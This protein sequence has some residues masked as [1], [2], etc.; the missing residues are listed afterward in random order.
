[1]KIEESCKNPRNVKRE[2]NFFGLW[3]TDITH[4]DALNIITIEKDKL[5]LL[6]QRKKVRLE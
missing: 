2:E 5:F 6:N 3:L 4:R 1:M